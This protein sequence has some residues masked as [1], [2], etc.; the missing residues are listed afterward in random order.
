M[1]RIIYFIGV[2]AIFVSCVTTDPALTNSTAF[3]EVVNAN[4]SSAA[5][6]YT[7]INLWFV[8]AFNSSESV[9][10]FSDKESGVIKGKY[11]FR[12]NDG[13]YPYDC[14]STITIEVKDEK[15]RISFALPYIFYYSLNGVNR[16]SKAAP[17]QS[18]AM[19]DVIIGNWRKLAE[20]LKN[21]ISI[22]T[23]DW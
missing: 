11:L 9:I 21:N 16:S 19:A 10:E 2:M 18:Q 6:L 4:G 7:H 8:D 1:K 3:S 23:A 13:L 5:D 20:D 22:Q 17:V 15:Y 14:Q 12:S